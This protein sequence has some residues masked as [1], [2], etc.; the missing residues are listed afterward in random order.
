MLLLI[1]QVGLM[2]YMDYHILSQLSIEI[3]CRLEIRNYKLI[4]STS[5][6]E[7]VLCF[8]L[9]LSVCLLVGYLKELFMDLHELLRKVW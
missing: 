2:A 6:L 7:Q 5:R 9:T 1:L 8:H 4:T 3:V